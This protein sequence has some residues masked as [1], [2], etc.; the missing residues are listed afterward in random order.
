[1]NTEVSVDNGRVTM[2]DALAIGEVNVIV[3]TSAK[4]VIVTG[5]KIMTLAGMY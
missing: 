3:D 1:M 2:H 4:V 5:V